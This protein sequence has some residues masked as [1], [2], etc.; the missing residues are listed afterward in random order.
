MNSDI[1]ALKCKRKWILG[2]MVICFAVIF[3]NVKEVHAETHNI[4]L[5]QYHP[6]SESFYSEWLGE[7][8]CVL[9]PNDTHLDYRKFMKYTYEISDDSV[10]GLRENGEYESAAYLYFTPDGNAYNLMPYNI[11]IH[12]LSPGSATLKVYDGKKLVEKYK[13]TVKADTVYSPS[14]FVNDTGDELG[15]IIYQ[16]NAKDT[17]ITK[18]ELNKELGIIKKFAKAAANEINVTTNQRI[19]AALNLVV[20]Y[21]SKQISETQYKALKNA[22]AK[23]NIEL[24]G[25]YWTAYSVL[26][27]KKSVSNGYALLNKAVLNN[28]GFKCTIGYLDGGEKL[29]NCE[30]WNYVKIYK[31]Y[32]EEDIEDGSSEDIEEDMEDVEEDD[33][34]DES[35]ISNDDANVSEVEKGALCDVAF[36]AA[37]KLQSEYDFNNA[38]AESIYRKTHLPAWING[39]DT[40]Q[41]IISAGETKKLSSSS[42]NDNV[43]SS[44]TSVVTVENGTITGVK[45]GV[46]VV[47]RYNDTYCDIF[48]VM[49]KQKG[50][51]KTI[52]A[53]I[54]KKNPKS[55]FTAS[56]Y[57]PYILDGQIKTHQL[58]DWENLRIFELE[59][60]FG[61]GGSIKTKYAKGKIN[62]YLN[63]GGNLEK[64]YTIGTHE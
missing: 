36:G 54:F 59:P 40:K 10:I 41:Q 58:D 8:Y 21:G 3:T 51:A 57:A 7:H 1:V 50:S 11:E 46:A 49:V 64:L 22:E 4:T 63:Y 52:Q 60:V 16:K 39:E 27:D 31:P 5:Y 25:R 15:D 34:E 19:M 62:I 18:K 33:T 35:I 17:V 24:I 6:K 55:Y 56:D 43:Y 28:L 37:G 29:Y 61:H 20:N 47:Y 13:F 14:S 23:R 9:Y 45:P 2:I 38:D 48:F 32:E 26:L 42:M 44:D 53:K 12:A 30:T